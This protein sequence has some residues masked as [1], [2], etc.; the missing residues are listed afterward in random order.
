MGNSHDDQLPPD[1]AD[2]SARLRAGRPVA[3][4]LILDRVMMRAERARTRQG[5]PLPRGSF[6]RRKSIAVV[7]ATAAMLVGS[8]AVA[9]GFSG[10][11]FGGGGFN[12]GSLV[13]IFGGADTTAQQDV[14]GGDFL[15]EV[16]GPGGTFVGVIECSLLEDSGVPCP[17]VLTSTNPTFV[18]IGDDQIP[19]TRVP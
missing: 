9:A 2:V 13:S 4:G 15:V 16:R 17:L 18:Q 14:Y 5:S 1:I 11:N 8:T 3:D 6:M 19:I 12:F 7:L 10:F